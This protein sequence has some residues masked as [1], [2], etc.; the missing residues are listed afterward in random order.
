MMCR[1]GALLLEQ[2]ELPQ[3]SGISI[4]A[5][6]PC[7]VDYIRAGK[8]NVGAFSGREREGKTE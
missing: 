6:L 8:L 1:D 5:V 4:S 2:F 3:Q 7:T